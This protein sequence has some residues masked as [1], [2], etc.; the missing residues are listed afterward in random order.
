MN[1]ERRKCF[2]FFVSFYYAISSLP[3]ERDQLNL[4]KAI[5]EYA[6]FDAEPQLEGICSAMFDLMRPNI[7]SSNA[8][9]KNGEKGGAPEGNQ[10]AAKGVGHINNQ[11]SSKKQ[12]NNNQNSRKKQ[13]DIEIEED[14]DI[15][16]DVDDGE[17]NIT[18]KNNMEPE[19]GNRVRGAGEGKEPH[20]ASDPAPALH[21]P[22]SALG[23]DYTAPSETEWN[24]KRQSAVALLASVKD[25]Q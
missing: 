24:E 19:A 13:P 15:D 9:R 23:G 25:G 16:N 22:P 11:N 3:D 5:A 12:A 20:S 18:Q 4:Y 7:D 6:L 1:N 8:R 17:R 10:N 21:R 2:T 14:K